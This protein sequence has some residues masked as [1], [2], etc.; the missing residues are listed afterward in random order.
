MEQTNDTNRKI[1][2]SS[3]K[4]RF[5]S[6]KKETEQQV[7]KLYVKLDMKFKGFMKV[8]KESSSKHKFLKD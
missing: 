1:Q 7:A 5:I 3:W 2:N 6:L 4:E 8:L